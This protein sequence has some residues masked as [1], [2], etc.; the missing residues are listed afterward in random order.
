MRR[1]AV[2]VHR[3]VVRTPGARRML[4]SQRRVER[5]QFQVVGDRRVARQP[6]GVQ[7]H[8]LPCDDATRLDGVVAER[9]AGRLFARREAAGAAHVETPNT[10]P[11]VQEGVAIGRIAR[12]AV[13]FDQS[14]QAVQAFPTRPRRAE[15]LAAG[16]TGPIVVAGSLEVLQHF[17]G[18]PQISLVARLTVQLAQRVDDRHVHFVRAGV[19]HAKAGVQ[20]RVAHQVGHLL[21]RRR[22]PRVARV[23]GPHHQA[24]DDVIVPPQVPL[25]A[26]PLGLGPRPQV[27]VV[28][29][30][31]AQP[32]D[33]VGQRRLQ[34]GIIRHPQGLDAGDQVLAHELARPG[35]QIR[36]LAG[37]PLGEHVEQTGIVLRSDG[38][39]LIDVRLDPLAGQPAQ[40]ELGSRN[41]V[42][43]ELADGFRRRFSSRCGVSHKASD[44]EGEPE[45]HRGTGDLGS[46][47]PIRKRVKHERFLL[48]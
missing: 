31:V 45:R 20:E 29:L 8:G 5:G 7:H 35:H 4:R 42:Q 10:G 26:Q 13:Q 40:L 37:I 21:S 43:R 28:G 39:P 24:E 30:Q 22:R 33:H 18:H 11:V 2:A 15:E 47:G 38:Q 17:P 34:L 23:F 1:L 36:R 19:E 9:I 12:D 16:Q 44:Q 48:D 25:P 14:L 6:Q 3:R 41:T 27:A 46:E 32:P